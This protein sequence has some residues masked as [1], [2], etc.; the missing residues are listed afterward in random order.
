MEQPKLYIQYRGFMTLTGSLGIFKT[1]CLQR[2]L[3]SILIPSIDSR[4]K[5]FDQLWDF[6]LNI[7]DLHDLSDKVELRACIDNKEMSIGW[8]RQT[9]YSA[10]MGKYS[11]QIDDDDQ[12][13]PDAILHI[14]E[15]M[16]GEPDCITFEEL[17]MIDGVES[18]SNFSLKYDDW[19]ENQDGFDHV[20]TPFF[21]TPIKTSLCQQ[22]PV[23]DMR[24]GEDHEWAKKIKHNLKTEMHIP[25]MLYYYIR[26]STPH[27]ER[28]GIK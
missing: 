6:L 8:K 27:N 10:A 9:L 7:I 16:K 3:L 19:A 4:N 14:L 28:Y 2:P 26:N 17:C 18:R 12:I 22:V 24:F 1:A 23:P 21:K 25:K 15:A 13:H 20:R 5:L 11:W